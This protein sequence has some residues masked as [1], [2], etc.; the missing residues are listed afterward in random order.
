M[1]LKTGVPQGLR[2]SGGPAPG[3]PVVRGWA[4]DDRAR[5]ILSLTPGH[6][7]LRAC[8]SLLYAGLAFLRSLCCTVVF[9]RHGARC[10]ATVTLTAVR[11]LR[12]PRV[13]RPPGTL[14]AMDPG[15]LAS[16]SECGTREAPSSP[17]ALGQ[18]RTP[19]PHP[20]GV[21]WPVAPK[22]RGQRPWP[23]PFA[24]KEQ[25]HRRVQKEPEE[26]LVTRPRRSVRFIKADPGEQRSH[27][28]GPQ[29]H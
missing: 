7:T 16:R 26:N 28:E 15:R 27:Q 5:P 20:Q 25:N 2:A 4:V 19:S 10:P 24:M 23:S 8:T 11:G 12:V 21:R 6:L 18:G 9:V 1:G 22:D 13:F 14:G 29:P 3:R 17:I